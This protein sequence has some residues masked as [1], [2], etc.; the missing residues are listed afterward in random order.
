MPTLIQEKVA[1]AI[2][3]LGEKDIDLWL[4][5]VRETSAV[6]DPVLPLI[7][8]R[9]LTWHSALILTLTGERIAILG[10]LES[11]TARRL[12]A[13]SEIVAYDQSIRDDLIRTLERLNPR[14]IA[15]NTSVND[16]SA[17]GLTHGLYT[18]LTGYLAGT[19][20]ADRLVSAEAVIAALRGRKTPAEASRIRQAVDT[21]EAIYRQTF[22]YMRPGMTEKQVADFMHDQIS[23][24]NLG[25]AWDWDHCPAVNAGP[26]S[27]VGHAAPTEIVLTPG[28]L[29][30]FDFG[31]LQEEY[32]S[33]IQRMVYL[34]RSGEIEAPCEVRR[35]FETIVQAIQEAV[36][37]MKP[38]MRG[39]EVDSVARGIV[40]AAGYPEYLYGTGHS[41]GRAA[42]DGGTMLGPLWEKYGQAP[43]GLLEE[44]QVYTVEPGLAV[45]GYG[46]IGLEEDVIITSDGA[47]FLSPPQKELVLL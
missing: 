47:E 34:R 42:H 29:V 22:E 14:Q 15:I 25:P 5:F 40:T 31:V 28:H 35:G 3:I 2:E 27:P 32:C 37:A 24:R 12:E 45:P 44:G 36:K 41:L 19:P 7:Y 30:H 43:Q 33:D 6:E 10:R 4:T 9:T 21:T 26:D 23:T 20:F 39:V 46:Y 11:D 16:P 17:D 38:G 8:G 13:Y 18:V 1:Q